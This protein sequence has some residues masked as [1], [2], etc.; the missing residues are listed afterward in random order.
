MRGLSLDQAPP[1]SVVFPF[2]LAA[3]AFA[4]AAGV[5]LATEGAI[6]LTNPWTP[7]TLAITHLGTI[8]FLMM[9]MMGAVYQMTPVVLGAPVPGIRLAHVVFV[10]MVIGIIALVTGLA[11]SLT[12]PTFV[13]IAVLGPALL[14][15]L[16]PTG[17]AIFRA[18]AR[19]ETAHGMRYALLCL[20][21]VG[22]LGVLMAHGHAAMRFPGDRWLFIRSHAAL[23]FLGWVGSLIVAV[24]WQ[25]V[26]MF[27]L[28]RE[29]PRW[30]RKAT[31]GA[32]VLGTVATPVALLLEPGTADVYVVV[33]PL[34]AVVALFVVHPAIT[35][36]SIRHRRR[37]RAHPSL[38]FWKAGLCTAPAVGLA[39]VLAA[40]HA[41]PRWDLLYGFLAVWGWAAVIV[42]GMLS[43]IAPFLVWFHRFSPLAGIVPIPSMNG[44]LPARWTE[45]GLVVH[46]ASVLAGAAGI[47]TGDD[48]LLRI[49]GVLIALTGLAIAAAIV[50]VLWQRPASPSA[51]PN[52]EPVARPPNGSPGPSRAGSERS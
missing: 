9:V 52:V 16:V 40:T 29:I 27:Y 10:S 47:V 13:A 21:A 5:L 11:L 3:S 12:T 2:F 17:W 24:S 33:A 48:S 4:M 20:L 39:A 1:L 50:R 30:Q 49:A 25:V 18:P 43:R 22:L 46:L 37:K 45:V 41:D 14:L 7:A 15:F 23:G 35:L 34:P 51:E 19:T 28:A 44:L 6:G 26:P 38:L 32:I 8:G 36:L 31:F 42:H